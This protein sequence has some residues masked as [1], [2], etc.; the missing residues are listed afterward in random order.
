[1]SEGPCT[2]SGQAEGKTR[3]ISGELAWRLEVKGY[4]EYKSQ[5]NHTYDP[6]IGLSLGL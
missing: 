3:H 5:V 4:L 6:V 1:M 2:L